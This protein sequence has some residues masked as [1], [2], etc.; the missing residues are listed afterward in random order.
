MRSGRKPVGSCAT[1]RVEA[2]TSSLAPPACFVSAS[3]RTGALASRARA[4]VSIRGVYSC[5]IHSSCNLRTNASFAF[6]LE[7]VR[8]VHFP[9]RRER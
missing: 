4:F 9:P 1:P 5:S 2:S 7:R 8:T 6:D 3:Y